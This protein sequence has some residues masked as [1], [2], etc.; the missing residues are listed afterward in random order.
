MTVKIF[1]KID[2]FFKFFFWKK[3]KEPKK[4]VIKKMKKKLPIS[5]NKW[6]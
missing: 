3:I 4:S 5:K 2:V 6:K 1:S